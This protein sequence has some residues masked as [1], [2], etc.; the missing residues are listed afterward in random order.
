MQ[1]SVTCSIS[2]LLK[3]V[4]GG[5]LYV[6][7]LTRR[8]YLHLQWCRL[9]TERKD[10]EVKKVMNTFQEIGLSKLM[11]LMTGRILLHCPKIFFFLILEFSLWIAALLHSSPICLNQWKNSC[12]ACMVWLAICAPTLGRC[13]HTLFPCSECCGNAG[14]KIKLLVK[15]KTQSLSLLALMGFKTCLT[16]SLGLYFPEWRNQERKWRKLFQILNAI[17]N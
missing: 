8:V 4:L 9:L 7:W 6:F 2:L 12:H 15:W 3:V 17:N 13:V 16:L 14:L 1:T 5:R 11:Y 10:S